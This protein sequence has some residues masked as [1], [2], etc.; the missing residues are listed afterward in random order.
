MGLPK[1]LHPTF[2][3]TIP[4]TKRILHFRPFLVKEEKILLIA[5]ASDDKGDIVKSIKQVVQNCIVEDDVDVNDFTTFDLEYFF[6]KLRSKSV[7]NIVKLS[8]KDREDGKIY[9]VEV[10]LEQVEV[11]EAKNVSNKIELSPTSGILLRYPRVNITEK[12]DSINDPV[13]FNFAII[14]SCIECV[15]EG[16]AVYKLKDFS[17]QEVKEYI[18]SLDVKT[19]QSIQNFIDSMPTIEH[20]VSYTNSKGR[21]VKIYLRTITDFFSLG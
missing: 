19:Y 17:K 11:Q 10:D 16:D 9:D 4:S 5:Q 1:I 7:Q 21:E 13:E 20:V 8:Y 12:I 18:D 6:I 14:E 15:Y 2:S 3:I